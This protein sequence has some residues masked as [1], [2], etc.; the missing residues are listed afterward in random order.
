MKHR[1][2]CANYCQDKENEVFHASTVK[3]IRNKNNF[4]KFRSCLICTAQ[5]VQETSHIFLSRKL[6]CGGKI[7]P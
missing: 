6:Y 1:Q 4:G 2:C 7:I 3:S 5:F